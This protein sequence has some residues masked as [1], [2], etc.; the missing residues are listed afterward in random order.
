MTDIPHI[1]EI[2]SDRIPDGH[3]ID[4]HGDQVWIKDG[5]YHRAD[6]PAVI[7]SRGTMRWFQHGFRHRS[8]GP[9][10]IWS[11]GEVEWSFKG[12]VFTFD[13]WLKINKELTDK[14]KLLLKLKYG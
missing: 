8:D 6:G 10:V 14:Q 3:W 12:L 2:L 13:D 9:A 5:E 11:D 1:D 7:S 4:R